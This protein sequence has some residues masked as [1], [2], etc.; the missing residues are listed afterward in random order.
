MRQQL[1]SFR[2]RERDL[3]RADTGASSS[4]SVEMGTGASSSQSNAMV[5]PPAI[6]ISTQTQISKKVKT[7][8]KYGKAKKD[9]MKSRPREELREEPTSRGNEHRTY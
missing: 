6:P 7:D 4:Q 3:M 1:A 8:M 9:R 5:S 2:T